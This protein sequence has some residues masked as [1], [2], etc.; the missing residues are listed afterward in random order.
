MRPA[1]NA[2]PQERP[3]AKRSPRASEKISRNLLESWQRK[4]VLSRLLLPLAL[5]YFALVS[6]R[7]SLYRLGIFKT[8]K[9]AV[10]VIVVG[11]VISGGAGKTP[12]TIAIVR[13][14]QSKGLAVGV[15]SRGYGRLGV[16]CKLV[17]DASTPEEVGDEPLLIFRATGAPVSVGPSRYQAAQ[18]LL[19]QQPGLDVLVC[20]DGLQHYGLHR[21]IEVCVFDNRGCGNGWPLPAGPLREPWPR[22]LLPSTGQSTRATLVL[23]TGNKPV[24]AGFRATRT[25]ARHAVSQSG[26]TFDL[27]ALSANPDKPL[28][29]VAGIAQP[30]AFFDMLRASRLHLAGTLGLADHADFAAFDTRLANNH[31]LLCT[32]KDAAK[33]WRVAP[34]ALAVPLLQTMDPAFFDALDRL[35]APH[36]GAKLS[37]RHGQETT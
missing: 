20:D 16:A 9:V 17:Q 28:F 26:Q 31:T 29:A 35:L 24:F 25:L 30:E 22:K 2:R 1:D 21:D 27:A 32:E 11:N 33:L 19:D 34:E 15:V 7:R 18:S 14:L 6:V 37:S 4:G 10:P 13:H 12:T 8:R 3:Q 5:L 36:W 23:H